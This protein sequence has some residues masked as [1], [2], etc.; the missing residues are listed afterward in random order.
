VNNI[1]QA[2]YY[3]IVTAKGGDPYCLMVEVNKAIEKGW[4]PIGG[5]SV[6]GP[7]LMQAMF[8]VGDTSALE[9]FNKESNR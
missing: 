2:P 3:R 1:E 9:K 8:Y 7:A 6:K 4:Q 5:V